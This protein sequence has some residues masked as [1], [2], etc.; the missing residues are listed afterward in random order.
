[1]RAVPGAGRHLPQVPSK[2]RGRRKPGVVSS[3]ALSRVWVGGHLAWGHGLSDWLHL[4]HSEGV[5]H[6]SPEDLETGRGQPA[7]GHQGEIQVIQVS[8][9]T[10]YTCLS[11]WL[12]TGAFNPTRVTTEYA[13]W[14]RRLDHYHD[15]TV[16]FSDIMIMSCRGLWES[17]QIN[18]S[19]NPL[20]LDVF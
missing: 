15:V 3:L 10:I 17:P 6:G 7:A 1:M 13:A 16:I 8:P 12:D 11:F 4:R 14:V 19:L 2:S 18:D 9:E 20:R 5:R